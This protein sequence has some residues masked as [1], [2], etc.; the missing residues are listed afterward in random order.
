[1]AFTRREIEQMYDEW[2]K[3]GSTQEFKDYWGLTS[4]E[5][6]QINSLQGKKED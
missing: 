1:M 4:E 3:S 5:I 2:F 6:K